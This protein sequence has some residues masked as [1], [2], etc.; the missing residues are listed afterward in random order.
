M[1]KVVLYVGDVQSYQQDVEIKGE[2]IIHLKSLPLFVG[3]SSSSA[4]MSMIRD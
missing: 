2:K 1:Y 3:L 4:S